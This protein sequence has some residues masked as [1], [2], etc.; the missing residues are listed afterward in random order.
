MLGSPTVVGGAVVYGAEDFRV[1]T[2]DLASGLGWSMEFT[3]GAI[4]SS[5]VPA[6]GVVLAGSDDHH[7]YAFKAQPMAP[8]ED[9]AAAELLRAM[10]GCYRTESG[11]EYTLAIRRGR[12]GVAFCTYP[13]A[14]AV[15]HPDGSFAWP[16]LWGTTGRCQ[17]AAERP[18]AALILSQFGSQTAARRIPEPRPPEA[19][20]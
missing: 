19:G 2:V 18:V 20:R 12:L 14:L 8:A 15:V 5:V 13:P 1:Y 6:G 4:Y 16:M 11:E 9:Q 3:E 17:N 10:E 7:L